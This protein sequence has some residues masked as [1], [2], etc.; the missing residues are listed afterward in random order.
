MI[1]NDNIPLE[2][3]RHT[4]LPKLVTVLNDE[5]LVDALFCVFLFSANSSS[6]ATDDEFVVDTLPLEFLGVSLNESEGTLE[7]A[8]FELGELE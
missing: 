8:N 6:E 1:A 4:V 5:S 3:Q 2:E 7:V